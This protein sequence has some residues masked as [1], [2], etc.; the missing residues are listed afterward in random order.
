MSTETTPLNPDD[1]DIISFIEG[2]NYPEKT[3]T[4]YTNGKAALALREA[5]SVPDEDQDGDLIKSLREEIASSGLTFTVRGL[6]PKIIEVMVK[7]LDLNSKD[8]TDEQRM[9]RLTEST[10]NLVAASIR[11]VVT[12]DGREDKRAWDTERAAQ[13][14]GVLIPSEYEKLAETVNTVNFDAKLFEDRVDAGF[15]R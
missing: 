14:R 13:L 11:K 5:T 1:F 4:V 9:E 6:A 2:S 12:A 7:K 10:D 8:L 3:V 15:P